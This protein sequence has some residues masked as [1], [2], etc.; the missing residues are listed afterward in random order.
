MSEQP[1]QGTV[2]V[3]RTAYGRAPQER[4]HLIPVPLFDGPHA[5]VAV[6]TSITRRLSSEFEFIKV[7]V[8]IELPCQPN[9]SDIMETADYA[10]SLIESIIGQAAPEPEGPAL[11]RASLPAPRPIGTPIA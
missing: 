10:N 1:D 6:G 9:Q 7:E 4:E 8:R 2:M 11:D 3:R 5:R